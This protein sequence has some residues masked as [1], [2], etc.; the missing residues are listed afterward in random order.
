ME[1][2]Y[3]LGTDN[4]RSID[5]SSLP[6]DLVKDYQTCLSRESFKTRI[7]VVVCLTIVACM[8]LVGNVVAIWVYS[9]EFRLS[10][11]RIFILCMGIQD[12][13]TSSLGLPLQIFTIY[14]AYDVHSM[15]YCRVMFFFTTLPTHASSAT[16]VAVAVDRFHRIWW[17]H[18][19]H[20]SSRWA[21]KVSVGITFVIWGIFGAFV[22][23][24][25][26]R[27]VPS[28][29]GNLSVIM[30][31]IDD[32][33]ENSPY[34][35]VY[36]FVVEAFFY[37]SF[38]FMA[39][40]YLLI[41]IQLWCRSKRRQRR[42]SIFA[43]MLPIKRKSHGFTPPN[44]SPTEEK[45]HKNV[46]VQTS[47]R[48]PY[49]PSSWPSTFT[50]TETVTVEE[51]SY[52]GSVDTYYT[53]QNTNT[54]PC[55]D[56]NTNDDSKLMNDDTRKVSCDKQRSSRSTP[57]GTVSVITA[58]VNMKRRLSR[59]QR[60][61]TTRTTRMM[62]VITLCY[63]LNWLPY[64]IIRRTNNEVINLCDEFTKCG[65]NNLHAL[66]LR[67]FFLSSAVNAFIY[68]IFSRVFRE[69]C[70]RLVKSYWFRL[71]LLFKR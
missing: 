50:V 3:V 26:T 22:P 7:P 71:V 31:W 38:L 36:I 63:I 34:K 46:P 40:S 5:G 29:V 54:K 43:P 1:C 27:T 32:D 45:S 15:G 60:R 19:R 64:V 28:Y 41:G 49:Q 66:G 12:L 30:C 14:H 69:K 39:G 42:P 37:S 18:R 62:A 58:V 23:L 56:H 2:N 65:A 9:M 55:P 47:M 61:L 21:V 17:P 57:L 25:G 48:L 67:S 51:L 44:Q 70:K 68:S 6:N 10:A 20:I 52:E 53:Q 4:L 33:Y 11:N 13:L 8:G 16:L 59:Q 24:Y 35:E